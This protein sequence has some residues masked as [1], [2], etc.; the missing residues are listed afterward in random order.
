MPSFGKDLKE[1]REAL[2]VPKKML[3][4]R[5]GVSVQTISNIENGTACK[6]N[7][8][9]ALIKALKEIELELKKNITETIIPQTSSEVVTPLIVKSNSSDIEKITK[10]FKAL[11]YAMNT[12]NKSCALCEITM[13][14]VTHMAEGRL[15]L[16]IAET[17]VI[18]ELDRRLEDL[19]AIKVTSIAID[20]LCAAD[21]AN[22]WVFKGFLMVYPHLRIR[23]VGVRMELDSEGVVR[24]SYPY[25]RFLT[26]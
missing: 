4:E 9:N 6:A 17:D 3:S 11:E 25:G 8:A 18:I 19:D 2:G 10:A 24:G 12:D 13:Q 15:G 5:S 14:L 23:L 1:V 16:P 7:T 22:Y 20:G 21:G 26:L